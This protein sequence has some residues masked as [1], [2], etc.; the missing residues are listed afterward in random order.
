MLN[1]QW[2][3]GF[4]GRGKRKGKPL[5][6]YKDL[7]DSRMGKCYDFYLKRVK[8]VTNPHV[9]PGKVGPFDFNKSDFDPEEPKLKDVRRNPRIRHRKSRRRKKHRRTNR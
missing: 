2:F 3:V 1:P 8:D 6:G 5:P 7:L 4:K 9:K